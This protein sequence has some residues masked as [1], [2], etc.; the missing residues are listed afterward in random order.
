MRIAL[1]AVTSFSFD[2]RWRALFG[3]WGEVDYFFEDFTKSDHKQSFK[4][5]RRAMHQKQERELSEN[6]EYDI[7]VVFLGTNTFKNYV[8]PSV[9][10]AV[11][12][13]HNV[14]VTRWP[15]VF[16]VSPKM[17]VADSATANLL[18]DY[19]HA[20]DYITTDDF[21]FDPN[22][23]SNLPD[24]SFYYYCAM[25]NIKVAQLEVS[26]EKL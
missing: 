23:S 4:Q 7:V 2:D 13:S 1:C 25:C 15:G 3:S 19:Y 9:K 10:P 5:L 11:I 17:F 26:H 6:F 14:F 22:E 18:A 12:Y 21:L 24:R 8:L 16:C 20:L